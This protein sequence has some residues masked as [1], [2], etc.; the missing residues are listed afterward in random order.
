MVYDHLVFIIACVIPLQI[1][2]QAGDTLLGFAIKN[3]DTDLAEYLIDQ[4][5]DVNLANTVSLNERL[6]AV[7][8]SWVC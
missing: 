1:L 3:R 5:A 2:V 4:K 6:I 8:L 7:S